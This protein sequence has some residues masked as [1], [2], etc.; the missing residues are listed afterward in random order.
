MV[1]EFFSRLFE[2]IKINFFPESYDSSGEFF[3]IF[4]DVIKINFIP[5]SN[6][7]TGVFL[8]AKTQ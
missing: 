1:R 3:N 7:S 8:P 4:L 6:G 2:V 5:G